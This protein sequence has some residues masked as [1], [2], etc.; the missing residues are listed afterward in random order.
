MELLLIARYVIRS[1]N[2]VL[3]FT[4]TRLSAS[5]MSNGERRWQEKHLLTQ[6]ADAVELLAMTGGLGTG[7]REM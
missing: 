2:G 6:P 3:G 4:S 5:D 7:R 1:L